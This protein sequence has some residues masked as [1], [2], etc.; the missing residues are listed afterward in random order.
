MYLELYGDGN[1]VRYTQLKGF[2]DESNNKKIEGKTERNACAK[3]TVS[4][5]EIFFN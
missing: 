1:R 5:Y 3:D 2:W 4:E